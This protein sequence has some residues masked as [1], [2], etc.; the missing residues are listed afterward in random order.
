MGDKGP[1]K[2]GSLEDVRV[3]PRDTG[4]LLEN[5]HKIQ[6]KV[7]GLKIIFEIFRK[8]LVILRNVAIVY[9]LQRKFG[10]NIGK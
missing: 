2:E 1:P 8:I 9:S 6:W 3:V 10:K 4:E 5:F 7:E